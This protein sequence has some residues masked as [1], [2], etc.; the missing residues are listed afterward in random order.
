MI[1]LLVLPNTYCIF[2]CLHFSNLP[3]KNP[4]EEQAQRKAY[5]E[6]VAAAK[7]KGITFM[8]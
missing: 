1:V 8:S 2:K 7:R 3:A 5:E 6:M 4:E